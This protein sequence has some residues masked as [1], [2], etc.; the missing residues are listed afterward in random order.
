MKGWCTRAAAPPAGLKRLLGPKSAPVCCTW[1]TRTSAPVCCTW[2][3]RTVH[4]CAARQGVLRLAP[5]YPGLAPPYPG[6]APGLAPPY[7]G[8]APPYPGLAPPYPGLAPG[9]P[10]YPICTKPLRRRGY[11]RIQL[12]EALLQGMACTAGVCLRSR[13]PACTRRSGVCGPVLCMHRVRSAPLAVDDCWPQSQRAVPRLCEHSYNG[14]GP[15]WG[16]FV[17]L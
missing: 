3:T 16:P 4:L 11:I 6:L 17:G 14:H 15:C 8:L 12:E 1:L 9:Y 7:P 2:L 13:A 5:G 10:A